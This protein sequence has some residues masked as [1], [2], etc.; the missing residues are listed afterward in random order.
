[1]QKH[2]WSLSEHQKDGVDQLEEFR[3]DKQPDPVA[4]IALREV[5]HIA[6]G[7]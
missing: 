3:S 5:V 2:E 4:I 1:M 7:I 6:V